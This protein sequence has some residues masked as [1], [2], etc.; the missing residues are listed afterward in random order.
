MLLKSYDHLRGSTKLL[1]SS[2]VTS[3]KSKLMKGNALLS[4]SL[5]LLLKTN[6]LHISDLYK[7][8]QFSLLRVST[9]DC[10][11]QGAAPKTS[12]V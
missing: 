11:L 12:L 5:L 10:H 9:V 2:S 8:I 3:E 6:N 1:L 4:T 7:T